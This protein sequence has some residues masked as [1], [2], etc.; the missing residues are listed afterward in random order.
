MKIDTFAA[1]SGGL[2]V[3]VVSTCAT[4]GLDL[5]HERK[6]FADSEI[7]AEGMEFLMGDNGC[8]MILLPFGNWL[9]WLSCVDPN[10]VTTPKARKAI[11]R[12]QAGYGDVVSRVEGGDFSALDEITGDKTARSAKLL[13]PLLARPSENS[14]L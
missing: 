3:N 1:P 4:F 14:P 2:Y 6:R 13:F 11:R 7:L 9:L 10:Q 5:E 8:G 12:L